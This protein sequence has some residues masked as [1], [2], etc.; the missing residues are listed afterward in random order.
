MI[1]LPK[2]GKYLL[3]DFVIP[4][5]CHGDPW[6]IIDVSLSCYDFWDV[7]MEWDGAIRNI[8]HRNATGLRHRRTDLIGCH[9]FKDVKHPHM[10]NQ[11][12]S[13]QL[14]SGNLT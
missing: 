2:K 10:E 3:L 6:R 4:M 7:C 5:M 9:G 11:L 12:A 1:G 14:P 13:I 8:W